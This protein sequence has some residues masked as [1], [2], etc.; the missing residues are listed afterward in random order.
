M[1]FDHLQTELLSSMSFVCISIACH[2]E[3]EITRLCLLY[4]QG[5][6]FHD[7]KTGFWFQIFIQKEYLQKLLKMGL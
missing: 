3:S 6:R 2:Q 5:G 4:K 1:Q 7:T